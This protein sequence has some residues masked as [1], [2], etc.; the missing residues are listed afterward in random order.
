MDKTTR[1]LWLQSAASAAAAPLLACGYRASI[2]IEREVPMPQPLKEIEAAKRY[3]ETLLRR[4]G[5]SPD[6]PPSA[7]SATPGAP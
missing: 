3:L 1:R 6:N 2:T 7:N 4:L 5:R